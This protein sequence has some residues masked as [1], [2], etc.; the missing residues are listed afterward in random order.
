LLDRGV[1]GSSDGA[2]WTSTDGLKVAAL[3]DAT[4][5]GAN[6]V[7][8]GF[9]F[10]EPVIN[11]PGRT[12]FV[13]NL[14][15]GGSVTNSNRLG[16]W[17]DRTGAVSLVARQGSL[18]AGTPVDTTFASFGVPTLNDAGDIAFR[19]TLTTGPGGV[20]NGNNEGIW[21]DHGGLMTLIAREGSAAPSNSP[22]PIR[23]LSFEDP[24][25]NH[26]SE[27]AFTGRIQ[28]AFGTL[29]TDIDSGLWAES[30]G[31]LKFIAREGFQAP[32]APAGAVFDDFN[33]VTGNFFAF[34][35]EG[36][37]AF[38]GEMKTGQGGVAFT[39]R[40][41]IW[42]TDRNGVLQ[43][44]VRVGDVL[45]V[46]PGDFRQISDL[47]FTTGPGP[48]S[49]GNEDGRPSG[50]SEGGHIAFAAQFTDF[51]AGIFVSSA[52]VPEPALVVYILF[53][54]G[55]WPISRVR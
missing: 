6:G 10:T 4:A 42:A 19:A 7:F 49:T 26:N 12:A 40:K 13:A 41:G 45:E 39:D 14:A 50:F 52:V 46:A 47:M 17:S 25:I 24:V 16:L 31:T 34:N 29:P 48:V 35:R 15:I 11:G 3:E 32:G 9:D 1:P 5:P 55:W 18:V 2:I 44:I 51:S 22:E 28:S 20:V 38:L 21:R 36:Q 8:G 54:V 23:F 53:A 30:G 27:V 43:L 33:G 37:L